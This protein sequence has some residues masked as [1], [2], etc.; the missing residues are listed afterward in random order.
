V[1]GIDLVTDH[2]R[3]G[4]T[5]GRIYL[6]GELRR[7]R[8]FTGYYLYATLFKMPI[9]T[10]V[11]LLT[12]AAAFVARRRHF[13]FLKNEMVLLVPIVFFTI[14]FNVFNRAQIGIRYFLV[15][16]PL[17]YV[18]AGSLVER[19]VVLTRRKAIGLAV[20]L[21]GLV[22]SV[23]SYFPHF[24]PYFN[25]LV[26]NRT[27]SYQILADSNIDWG[28]NANEVRQYRSEHP[29]AIVEP[30]APT[31]GTIL[32]SVNTLTGVLVDPEKFRWLREHFAPVGHIGYATLVYQVSEADLERFGLRLR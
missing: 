13:D 24:L 15:V 29:D 18:L 16:F 17:L 1:S 6:L 7:G 11:I 5:Y 14:Y 19:R 8:G 9:A 32:V 26:W 23:L 21:A 30:A 25:E 2:E 27:R 31:A 10:M 28:Q 4:S 22:L 12:T 20:A 3:T